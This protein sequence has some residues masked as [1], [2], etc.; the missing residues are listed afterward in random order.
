MP[1]W[2]PKNDMVVVTDGSESGIYN[3]KTD[4][5][6]VIVKSTAVIHGGTPIRPDGKG[7]LLLRGEKDDQRMV[8][9]DWEGKDQKIDADAFVAIIPKD[10]SPGSPIATTMLAALLLPSGWDGDAAWVGFKRDKA[11]Y[12]VDTAKKKIEFTEGFKAL[13]PSDQKND[14]P[15]IRFDFGG[16]ITV[17]TVQIKEQQATF[18][19]VVAVN[20]KTKKEETLLDKGPGMAIFLPSPDGNYLALC[21]TGIG[22]G[23]EDLILVINNQG[24]LVSKLS[25]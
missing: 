13:M 10:K 7:F 25:F 15:P 5:L 12:A 22:P 17:K 9:M 6:K 1:F 16:D 21:L 14:P 4:S 8:F 19:K 24:E 23:Q 20:N 2:S 11:T 18:N 3:V